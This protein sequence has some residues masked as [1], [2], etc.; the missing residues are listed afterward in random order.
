MYSEKADLTRTSSYGN[1]EDSKSQ[2]K[3]D[4]SPLNRLNFGLRFGVGYEYMGISL[5]LYY[6]WMVTNTANKNYWDGNRWTIL[7]S[8]DEYHM[9][10]YSQ[11]NNMLM[12]TVGYTFRY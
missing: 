8:N 4:A 12:V 5:S 2:D 7:Q 6:Q 3:M 1:G 10:G 11:R 9:T